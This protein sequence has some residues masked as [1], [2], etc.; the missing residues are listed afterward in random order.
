MI[1]SLTIFLASVAP[2]AIHIKDL[3]SDLTHEAFVK[4]VKKFGAVKPKS[5][6]IREYPEVCFSIIILFYSKNIIA[7]C[8][9]TCL[10]LNTLFRTD[11]AM[12]L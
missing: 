8:I 12:H 1:C 3:P 5:I 10:I 6:Q 7:S 9:V 4:E 11:I 2:K